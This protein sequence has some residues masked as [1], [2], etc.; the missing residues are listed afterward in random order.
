VS[1]MPPAFVQISKQPVLDCEKLPMHVT[2]EGE[3]TR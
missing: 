2:S 1:L 3:L